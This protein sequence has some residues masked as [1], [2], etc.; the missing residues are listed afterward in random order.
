MG[1]PD[2]EPFLSKNSDKPTQKS[3]ITGEK[4]STKTRKDTGAFSIRTKITKGR[5]ADWANQ[6]D[7]ATIMLAQLGKDSA[8]SRKTHIRMRPR[9]NDSRLSKI[10]KGDDENIPP[11]CGGSGGHLSGQWTATREDTNAT[12]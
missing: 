11:L 5:P 6:N 2:S 10:L 12:A 9:L 4:R 3:V 1:S 8:R 7:V